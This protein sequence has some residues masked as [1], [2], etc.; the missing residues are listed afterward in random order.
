[1][2]TNRENILQAFRDEFK[3]LLAPDLTDENCIP[4]DGSPFSDE[5]PR[6]NLPYITIKVTTADIPVGV[7]ERIPK[8]EAPAAATVKGRGHRSGTVSVNGFGADSAGWLEV[9]T[10]RLQYETSIRRLQAAGI[11]VIN[12]GGGVT[13]LSALVDTSIEARFLREFEISYSVVDTD[14]EA[15][16]E[17]ETIEVDLILEDQEN[18]PD[19]LT[20]TIVIDL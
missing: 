2:P 10:L 5:N 18:D 8:T 20:S 14:A 7:D 9:F 11:A 19:P 12:R 16:V 6:P 3:A 13:D 15:L 1:M 17:A 4:A